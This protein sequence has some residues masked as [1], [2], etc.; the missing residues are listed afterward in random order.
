MRDLVAAAESLLRS[1]ELSNAQAAVL[2]AGS[3]E[4]PKLLVYVFD[5][6]VKTEELKVRNWQGMSVEF[7]RMKRVQP[8]DSLQLAMA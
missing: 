2:N 8:H 1:L 3:E 5:K 4:C 6:R 7:V